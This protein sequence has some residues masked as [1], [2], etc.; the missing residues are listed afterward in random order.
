MAHATCQGIDAG[1]QQ[2][3]GD[4]G[5]PSVDCPTSFHTPDIHACA[6]NYNNDISR[7]DGGDFCPI[8]AEPTCDG[9]FCWLVI[10]DHNPT[11]SGHDQLM[12]DIFGRR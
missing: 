2:K 12:E 1:I 5:V 8:Q 7:C 11:M 3:F 10:P 6:E 4:A 9:N